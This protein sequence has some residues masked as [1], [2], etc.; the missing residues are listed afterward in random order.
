MLS[1]ASASPDQSAQKAD[2]WCD[3]LEIQ[4]WVQS[5]DCELF[6]L[7]LEATRRG[8][9]DEQFDVYLNIWIHFDFHARTSLSGIRFAR[10]FAGLS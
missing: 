6:L 5:I 7:G 4:E 8:V 1:T 3:Q 10:L 2:S 9:T